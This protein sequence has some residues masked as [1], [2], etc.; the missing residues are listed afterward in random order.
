[1][2]KEIEVGEHSSTA[3]ADYLQVDMLG[4]KYTSVNFGAKRAQIGE[5][6]KGRERGREGEGERARERERERERPWL[7][8]ALR[9]PP[10]PL[11]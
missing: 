10:P 5:T 7:T 6:Q 8:E 2:I 4:L 3:F 11:P 9:P 1:M